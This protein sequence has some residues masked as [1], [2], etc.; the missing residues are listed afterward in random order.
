M[1]AAHRMQPA[2]NQHLD[3]LQ[4]ALAP[5]PVARRKINH[6]RRAFLI[7]AFQ[8]RQQPRR[9]AAARN[10]R[11]LDKVVAQDKAAERPFAFEFRQPAAVDKRPRADNRVMPPVVAVARLPVCQ[12]GT[13]HRPR[14]FAR[15]LLH[16]RKHARGIDHLRRRLD[17]PRVRI[18][19]H[20]PRHFDNRFRRHQ[21]VGVQH[22]HK[23]VFCPPS[24]AEI[25]DVAGL[26]RRILRPPP[27]IDMQPRAAGSSA[28][29]P[30]CFRIRTA[31]RAACPNAVFN[32][33]S[34]TLPQLP[35]L[36]A[37]TAA[38]QNPLCLQPDFLFLDP[39]FR[40]RRI[41]QNKNIKPAACARLLQ[42]F[43]DSQQPRHHLRR[44]FVV[45]RHQH[46]CLRLNKGSHLPHFRRR[47]VLPHLQV[48]RR[49]ACLRI[50]R[51]FNVGGIRYP[52][53]PCPFQQLRKS[54]NARPKIKRNP[55]ER[56][57][58]QHNHRRPRPNRNVRRHR[59]RPLK[60]SQRHR[61][62]DQCRKQPPAPVHQ[63]RIFRA[64]PRP[65][66]RAVPAVAR[67]AA[68]M[69]PRAGTVP[70]PVCL[71][72]LFPRL[73]PQF[74]PHTLDPRRHNRLR[75]HFQRFFRRHDN[76]V[77]NVFRCGHFPSYCGSH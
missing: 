72:P 44:L 58:K 5:A 14:N 71:A 76:Q 49:N 46:R 30:G 31:L 29:P 55:P 42:I 65:Q 63:H 19:F 60:Q 66:R 43:A 70:P 33:T 61:N 10:Q 17:N 57:H 41:A 68:R 7:A 23:V 16:P 24:V 40:I 21:A 6:R 26:A 74:L 8:F 18:C 69:L 50:Q 38:F 73:Q 13:D 36:R 27:V 75:P 53:H 64:V 25:L 62:D 1:H 9:P 77:V 12:P 67:A 39:D 20:Q 52:R 34:R 59:R 11:R 45:N 15:K 3:M 48:V 47:R 37:E 28:T 4:I 2:R 22:Q 56:Q 51:R 54:Q 32:R 35:A